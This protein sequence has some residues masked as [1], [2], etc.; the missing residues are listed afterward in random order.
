M[1]TRTRLAVV[2]NAPAP[3]RLAQSAR[4]ARELPEIENFTV[5]KHEHNNSPWRQP[6]PEIIAPV[7]FGKGELLTEKNKPKNILRQ[8]ARGGEIIAWL[9][10]HAIDALVLT[11]YNDLGLL[12]IIRWGKETGVPVF[13]FNDSNVYGDRA[14]GLGRALKNFYVPKVVRMLAGLM[15]CSVRGVEFYD[16]YGGRGKPTFYMPHEPDYA[17]IMTMPPER[18]EAAREKHGLKRGR[19]YINYCAR[20]TRVKRPDLLVE[21]FSSI[22]DARPEWD[23]CFVGGGDL[24]GATRDLVPERYRERFIFTDFVDGPAEIAALYRCAEVHCLP[25]EYE[26]W[27]AVIPEAA[28]AGLAIV[29]SHVVGAASELVRD[30]VNGLLFE[31][32]SVEALADAL[33]DVTDEANIDRYRAGSADV[34]RD[35]RTRGDPIDGVRRALEFSGIL[36]PR[37]GTRP[38]GDPDKDWRTDAEAGVNALATTAFDA[39]T[40]TAGTTA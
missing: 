40:K 1:K 31:S 2:A 13:M 17:L 33:M 22:A 18:V 27:A 16:R 20:M 21:A 28:A 35:W 3:Y 38:T 11:G 19:R 7:V 12:R 14:S 9:E 30:A 39:P 10:R 8:W 25:S 4:I 26:P 5:F 32:G 23:V 37:S 29:S 6:L 24:L 15:P 34:L 36:E